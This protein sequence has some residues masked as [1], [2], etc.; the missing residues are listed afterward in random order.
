MAILD[1]PLKTILGAVVVTGMIGCGDPITIVGSTDFVLLP[2]ADVRF[3]FAG[4]RAAGVR[5][6]APS[7][8]AFRAF[9]KV[10]GYSGKADAEV[11][12]VSPEAVTGDLSFFFAHAG[13]EMGMGQG[14]WELFFRLGLLRHGRQQYDTMIGGVPESLRGE[15]TSGVPGLGL[16]G[17]LRSRFN[18]RLAL[19]AEIFVVADVNWLTE[20]SIGI[21]IT[22]NRRVSV[23]LGYAVYRTENW[24]VRDSA[25][26]VY[27]M[28]FTAR[29]LATGV[30]CRF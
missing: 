12:T 13:L 29:C 20:G 22:V 21:E 8:H 27:W 23:L 19:A 24:T 6:W 1:R 28:D 3:H 30:M 14:T 4:T 5:N 7:H 26:N 17:G 11:G 10:V 2:M 15:G 25:S 16:G 9:A 18:E